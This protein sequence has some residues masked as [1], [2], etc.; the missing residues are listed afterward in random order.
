MKLKFLKQLKTCAKLRKHSVSRRL[1]GFSKS[2]DFSP[3]RVLDQTWSHFFFF[4]RMGLLTLPHNQI[5]VWQIHEHKK[6]FVYHS[7]GCFDFHSEAEIQNIYS[8]SAL[9][10]SSW[11]ST[12]ITG[13][14]EMEGKSVLKNFLWILQIYHKTVTQ[15][16]TRI[17]GKTKLA[18]RVW[19]KVLKELILNIIL[20]ALTEEYEYQFLYWTSARKGS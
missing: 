4:I 19:V 16:L 7:K 10:H 11:K 15:A 8:T 17:T 12:Q 20:N 14:K 5:H 18:I 1:H 13:Y 3:W 9:L 2:N 6:T